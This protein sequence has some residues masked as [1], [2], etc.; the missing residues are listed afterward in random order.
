MSA[1]SE[2]SQQDYRVR[3][4]TSNDVDFLALA[5]RDSERAHTGVGIWDVAI[6]D[7][8]SNESRSLFAVLRHA[9]LNDI[10]SH[11]HYSHFLV[12]TV[13][14]AVDDEEGAEN[15]VGAGCCY[16][17]PDFCVPKSY[18]GMSLATRLCR[19]E[20][21]VEESVRMWD[22]IDI[23]LDNVFPSYDYDN[24]WMLE[25][26]YIAEGHRQSG[27]G[28]KLIQT[29]FEQGRHCP[30]KPKECLTVCAIGNYA[31]YRAYERAGFTCV[32][33]GR[34]EKAEVAL[35]YPGFH[36]FRKQYGILC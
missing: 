5:I 9:C 11:F 16:R 29:L 28:V 36:L 30:H 25:S 3:Q 14:G 31:A 22:K 27:L 26:I 21:S 7:D 34:D 12:I 19:P 10:Q 17:Y 33:D 35:G 18:P 20:V 23:F 4:A 15:I 13:S 6:G 32:G 2:F 1:L 8:V 24:T